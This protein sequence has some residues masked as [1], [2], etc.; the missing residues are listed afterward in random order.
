M[1]TLRSIPRSR[2]R[3]AWPLYDHATAAGHARGLIRD[4]LTDLGLDGGLVDDAVEHGGTVYSG[5]KVP[6]GKGFF[7][8][9]TVVGGIPLGTKILD[10]E[11]FG[12]VAPVATFD[13]EEQA[14]TLANQTIFGLQ[15]YLHTGDPARIMRMLPKLE[16][17]LVSVNTGTIS[18]AAAP[19]GGMKQSGL[20]REGG[21]E[22]IEEYLETQ[23]IGFPVA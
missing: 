5:G 8:P 23:Y 4:F 10:T 17:G 12:P 1:T 22:G 15:G 7:Y 13:T 21:P 18:N 6:E 3:H 11:I 2:G 9:P 16:I 20:G 14:I 19:F